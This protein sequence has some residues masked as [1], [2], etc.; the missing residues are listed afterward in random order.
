MH[1]RLW[2]A[3][4]I[5]VYQWWQRRGSAHI[6]ASYAT[7]GHQSVAN[8]A[9]SG[10]TDP[11]TTVEFLLPGGAVSNLHMLANGAA[12]P[13]GSHRTGGQTLKLPVGSSVTS[14]QISYVLLPAARNDL[15]TTQQ[16]T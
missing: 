6:T 10:A 1:P 15:Y 13:T 8:A 16:G 2:P 7:N 5:D 4:A 9:I 14:A 12:A 11:N 3:N